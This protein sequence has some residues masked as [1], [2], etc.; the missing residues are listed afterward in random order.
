MK[1]LNKSVLVGIASALAALGNP[2]AAHAF[3]MKKKQNHLKFL[4]A[5]ILAVGRDSAFLGLAMAVALSMGFVEDADA[6]TLN[7]AERVL[8]SGRG[9]WFEADWD[10]DLVCYLYDFK[11]GAP[12]HLRVVKQPYSRNII[13]GEC[14]FSLPLAPSFAGVGRVRRGV[15][16]IRWP[17]GYAEYI[18]LGGYYRQQ[19][20]LR[21]SRSSTGPSWWQK[22]R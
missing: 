12:T 18:G 20:Y 14:R 13:T 6:R 3:K 16:Q 21:I 8:T 5:P 15:L 7:Q 2:S 10:N 19:G 22:L 1:L 4:I 9:L 17:S 11:I